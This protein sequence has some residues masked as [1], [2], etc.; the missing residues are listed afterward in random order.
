MSKLA[1]RISRANRRRRAPSIVLSPQAA[2]S[3]DTAKAVACVVLGFA[4][5]FVLIKTAA[6]RPPV[7][8]K[9]IEVEL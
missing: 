5:S 4:I 1:R 8:P 2:V 7:G 9:V 3:I 6:D